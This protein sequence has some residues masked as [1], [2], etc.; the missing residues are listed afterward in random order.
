MWKATFFDP[1][2]GTFGS[3]SPNFLRFTTLISLVTTVLRQF[4]V[5]FTT[6][7]RRLSVTT[8]VNLTVINSRISSRFMCQLYDKFFPYSSY[9]CDNVRAKS[10]DLRRKVRWLAAKFAS[11]DQVIW[12]EN[13]TIDMDPIRLTYLDRCGI[14]ICTTSQV[15]NLRVKVRSWCVAKTHLSV[16]YLPKRVRNF[17]YIRAHAIPFTGKFSLLDPWE[18]FSFCGKV[19]CSKSDKIAQIVGLWLVHQ[20]KFRQH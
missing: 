10:G 16:A 19:R 4:Y 5:D 20:S 6:V 7:L 13:L 3:F 17:P 1:P 2:L 8:C 12:P 15:V 9:N 14:G 11:K 18:K